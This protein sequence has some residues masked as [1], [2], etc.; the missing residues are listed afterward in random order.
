MGTEEKK[1]RNFRLTVSF[2][3]PADF[4]ATCKP[5]LH[6]LD[7]QAPYHRNALLLFHVTSNRIHRSQ[8]VKKQRMSPI[9]IIF[10]LIVFQKTL[11]HKFLVSQSS[12]AVKN[13]N[14]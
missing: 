8:G 2:F 7:L 9:V 12:Q 11:L 1:T 4:A 14:G 5:V 3:G 6:F 13:R 10:Q